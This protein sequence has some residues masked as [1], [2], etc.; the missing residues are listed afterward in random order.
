[1]DPEAT[2]NGVSAAASG[3]MTA[4]EKLR[5]K[6][7][8]DAAHHAMVEDVADE[9]DIAHP[10]PSM[11]LPTEPASV[12]E[13]AAGGLSANAVGKQKAHEEPS[14]MPRKA[15]SNGSAPLNTQSEESFPALG[16]GPKASAAT[17]ATLAWGAKK[18][19]P[20]HTGVDGING[21]V[22]IPSMASSR[23]ST[24]TSGISTPNSANVSLGSSSRGTSFPQQMTLPGRHSERIQ[25][26][27]SQLLPRNQLKKSL[28]DTLRE[29]NKRSKA[30]V[31]MRTGANGN[32][33][34]EGKGP[35]DA[36]RQLLK[37]LA[38][39]V[40]SKQ[41]VKV[42]IPLSVRPHVI[43]RHGAVIQG[44]FKRTGA[45]VRLPKTEELP[46][47]TEN[48][49]DSQTIDVSIEGDAVA[50]EMA[51]REIESIVNERTSTV[52]LRLRDVP[53]EF[54]PF[55][56]GP[57]NCRINAL[58]D[59]RQVRVEVPHYHTWSDQA[60]PQPSSSG[61][62]PQFVPSPSNHIRISGDRLAAQEARTEIERQV[63]LL[64]KQI[65]LSQ[66][67]IDRGRHQFI[68]DEDNSLH[69]LL[70]ETG[71][72]IILP[73]SSEDTELLTITGPQDKLD[74][75]MDKVIELA[76]AMQ[77]SRIDIARQHTDAP[78]GP[79]AHARAL[80]RYLQQRRAIEQ[81]ERQYNARIVLPDSE[82][83]S[84]DWEVY[85]KD[86]R[87][88][89]RARQDI[90]N[91]ISAH[92]PTRI[93]HVAIDRFFH[94]H[95]HQQS[96]SRLRDDFGVHLIQPRIEPSEHLVLVYEGPQA[97]DN[98]TYQLPSQPP[99]PQDIVQ[100]ER[101]LQQAQHHILS[102]IQG[103][104]DIST[105][106]LEAPPK[107]HDK[108][109][110]FVSREQQGLPSQQVPVQI[111]FGALSMANAS[112]LR[113]QTPIAA[114]ALDHECTLRGPS[115]AVADF[116]AKVAAYIE[117]EKN[118]ELER[119][120]VTSFGFPQ[121]HMSYLIGRKGENIN[122]YRKEFDVEI[123]TRDGKVDIIGPKAKA[124]L[125]KAKIIALSK[126][127]EDESTHVLKIPPRYHREIIG[128]RGSQ[129]N[130]LRDRYNVQVHFP[131]SVSATGDDQSVADDASE[132]SGPRNH[133]PNQGPDEVIIKGPSK[134]ADA[135]REELL[136]L[137]QW[138]ID[139][140]HSSTVSVAQRQLPSLIG[141]GGQEM[142]SVR[143]ATGAQIDVP[144]KDSADASGR[145]QIHL[146]GSK[147][148]VEEA[149]KIL[150]QRAKAFDDTIMKS[151][152]VDRKYH[153]ALI[154]SGGSN[155]RNIV[156]AAGGSDDPRD[157]SR[158]VRFPRQDSEESTIRVEGHKALVDKLVASIEAFANQRDGQ[159][160]EIIE[161][162]PEKHR[163][164]IGRG[165]ESRRALE[166]QF[167][168][169]LNIPR[170]SDQGPARSQ[171][172]VSGQPADVDKAKA[173]ILDM[174]QDLPSETVHVPRKYHHAVAGNG[175]L[176]RRLRTDHDVTVDHGDQ[177]PPRRP[178][179]AA[180]SQTDGSTA[181]PLITDDLSS[182]N[183]H[184]FEIV[185]DTLS[186]VEEG[187]IPWILKGT[188]ENTAKARA[189]LER[190]LKQAEAQE[191]KSTGYL[192]LPDPRTYRFVIGHGGSKINEI[193]TLTDCKITVPRDQAPGSA[194]EIVGSQAGVEQ[195]RDIILDAVQNT[196]RR[197]QHSHGFS[198]P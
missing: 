189:Q 192:V 2:L 143:L 175:Q 108:L 163:L 118:N 47:Q 105:A 93:K 11:Q 168:V 15:R 68:L 123:Q 153:K 16:S 62:Q 27:P 49:D 83:G 90:L 77:V 197:D 71:C 196:G 131:R 63:E 84:S 101:N 179:P 185:H 59:G 12:P 112:L 194:I 50:A 149:R 177:K 144:A 43:G 42:P 26:A 30:K 96:A 35:V 51:R 28:Q 79:Q 142:E 116:A 126:K 165:G 138:T 94:E 52:N 184:S 166:S 53:A 13:S 178:S 3:S 121:Q 128:A 64:R 173:H 80:T 127:L 190:A 174:I 154:G 24:P 191:S 148:Q 56:A 167:K 164:L 135:A 20:L 75:G 38:K 151:V 61:L 146:K 33:I 58:E 10:A 113:S 140:S 129:V 137:L 29:L 91:M 170:L 136:S 109:R 32:V 88:G 76:S 110:N 150:E 102:L 130:R 114:A 141:Q 193:R 31:E 82:H 182:T 181:M 45:S 169:D 198:S 86:G 23:A 183:A 34:F 46:P 41:H 6:H 122:K 18:P 186:T 115:N 72:A 4:A 160:T 5:Q 36:T 97:A 100:S 8:A 125:A 145:V 134:G 39:E 187:T 7:E 161:V 147:K 156:V 188:P 81:L 98:K 119:G 132:L 9:E 117:S 78:M 111:Y 73:P 87:N 172:K 99:S 22:R 152:E 180:R 120:H 40:G 155:I 176:L 104:Q 157:M 107:Y 195:A 55:I 162:P 158:T 89:I 85:V 48:Y 54:F 133:R 103:Q 92:P 19:S 65:T 171:V 124:E 95:I 44:I 106:S 70:Q 17:Q 139:N 159:T 60:P 14:V 37:D 69:E 74:S 67:R 25:F 1:M 21:H 57:H 66:V